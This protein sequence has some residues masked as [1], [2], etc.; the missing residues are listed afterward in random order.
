MDRQK[1]S[2]VTEQRTEPSFRGEPLL[3]PIPKLGLSIAEAAAAVGLSVWAIRQA[4]GRGELRAKKTGRSQVVLP[5]DLLEWLQGL[6]SVTPSA[7]YSQKYRAASLK[8]LR[9]AACPLS[10]P[11]EV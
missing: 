5:S 11:S 2:R 8:A 3:V 4:V 9:G 10:S 1:A 6:D 7:S